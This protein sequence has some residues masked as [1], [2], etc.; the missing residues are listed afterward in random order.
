MVKIRYKLTWFL[1]LMVEKSTKY[2]REIR[3]LQC[4][5]LQQQQ[6]Q[7]K[8]EARTKNFPRRLWEDEHGEGGNISPP[9]SVYVIVKRYQV[10]VPVKQKNLCCFVQVSDVCGERNERRR[11]SSSIDIFSTFQY[12]NMMIK[13]IFFK[14]LS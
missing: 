7:S 4:M 5:C 9:L 1:Y 12:L 13:K 8:R 14:G 6:L 2:A 10:P 3:L 11:W